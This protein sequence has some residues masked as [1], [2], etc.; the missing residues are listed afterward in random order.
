MNEAATHYFISGDHGD[1]LVR[2][3]HNGY[4]ASLDGKK[5][6]RESKDSIEQQHLDHA[7]QVGQRLHALELQQAA[8]CKMMANFISS[9]ESILPDDVAEVFIL[10]CF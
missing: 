4:L 10:Y 5:I 7:Q 6:T 2:E 8:M 3:T 9:V 1:A